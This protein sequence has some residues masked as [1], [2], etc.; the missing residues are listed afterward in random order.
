MR[1]FQN[2]QIVK[3]QEPA[4]IIKFLFFSVSILVSLLFS[5]VLIKVAGADLKEAAVSLLSGA[6]WGKREILETLVK[7][8]PLMFT[9]LATAIAFRAKIWNIGQ[10]GQLFGGAM[11]SYLAYSLFAGENV[12]LN[13]MISLI[14]GLM[15]GALTGLIPAIL[16]IHFRVDEVLSTVILNYIIA[17]FLSFMLS[18]LGPWRQQGSFYQQTSLINEAAKW[19]MLFEEYRL[20]IGFIIALM[21]AV[22]LYIIMKKL[23]L[24]YEIRAFGYNST[25]AET[26]GI[27]SASI[28][29]ATLLLSGGLAGLAGVGEVFGAEFRLTSRISP[30][31]GFSG[32]I[33][34][35]VGGLNPLGV[36]LASIFFGGLLNGAVRLKV[37]TN[38]PNALIDVIQATV[39]IALLISRVLMTYRIRRKIHVE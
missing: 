24:G 14:A 32:I 10:E 23:P 35:I 1:I 31:Y 29:L 16:K 12:I 19:P 21:A 9:G 15:G 39:L 6:F 37:T 13:V 22:L 3:R 28:I 5:A 38:V 4:L 25:A 36:V 18:P 2:Y 27:S 30:G 11:M 20:H 17:Y 33:V 8:T 34:A 7:S 26:Q